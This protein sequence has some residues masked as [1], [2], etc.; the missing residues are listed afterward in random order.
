M[1]D[2]DNLALAQPRMMRGGTGEVRRRGVAL[3]LSGGGYRAML[4]HLGVLWRLNEAGY[5]PRLD[6][7]SSVSGG[8]ITA[9][10]LGLAWRNLRFN[11]VGQAVNFEGRVVRPV[12]RLAGKTI[13]IWAVLLGLVGPGTAGDYIA[14][15][16]QRYLFGRRTLQDLPAYGHGPLFVINASNLQSGVLWRFSRAYTWDYR[17]GK[18]GNPQIKLSVAVAASSAFPPFLSPI[19]LRY[20]DSDYVPKSGLDLQRPS[21]TTRVYLTD[22]GVY[23][24]LGLEPAWKSYATLLVS[25]G[26]ARLSEEER[27]NTDWP[28]HVLR[29]F[30]LTDN[31]VRSLRKRQLM[32]LYLLGARQGGA[33]GAYWGIRSHIRRY[34]LK[35]A[36]PCPLEQTTRL[37]RLP[38]RLAAIDNPAQERLINWGYA[39]CDA[40]MRRRVDV[41]MRK[42]LGFPYP[43]SG[44]G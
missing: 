3:C 13:D 36:L 41:L 29:I 23:D 43:A 4:F 35:D 33:T 1:E 24:N 7:I 12:R 38:T 34:G 42:P 22:G 27:P 37:A 31:P 44:V 15:A 18:I 14:H 32:H 21:Y 25:D 40:A 10:V 8:S 9:G 28:R 2:F 16:Y 26:G 19:V 30:S 11:G 39:V 5:L 17:V 20:K 6:L